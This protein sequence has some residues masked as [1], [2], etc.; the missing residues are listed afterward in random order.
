ML[1]Q[2]YYQFTN[3]LIHLIDNLV[4]YTGGKI[5]PAA[6]ISPASE[7]CSILTKTSGYLHACI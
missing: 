4:I 7:G 3:V 2:L 5:I 1:I 6:I